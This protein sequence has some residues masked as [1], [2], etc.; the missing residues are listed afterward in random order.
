MRNVNRLIRQADR[1]GAKVVRHTI[2]VGPPGVGSEYRSLDERIDEYVQANIA[3][4]SEFT[5]M[6]S[7][8]LGLNLA[9]T[10]IERER[11]LAGLGEAFLRVA[12]R[13][14]T[15]D[16]AAASAEPTV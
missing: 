3:P 11:L 14:D 16:T 12:A 1:E 15:T 6:G 7:S 10:N 13:G 2:E 5:D 8:S 4:G 9:M